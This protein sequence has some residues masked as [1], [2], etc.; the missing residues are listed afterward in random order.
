[1]WILNQVLNMH[2]VRCT[3]GLAERALRILAAGSH[4]DKIVGGQRE[5]P[6]APQFQEIRLLAESSCLCILEAVV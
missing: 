4:D 6:D 1:M 3:L 2:T 5:R